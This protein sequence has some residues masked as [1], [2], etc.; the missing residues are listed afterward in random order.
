MD[1]IYPENE[2]RPQYSRVLIQYF[3][4]YIQGDFQI[5]ILNYDLQQQYLGFFLDSIIILTF[6][7][8]S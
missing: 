2:Q 7:I 3:D 5:N 4:I 6:W 8:I 1:P